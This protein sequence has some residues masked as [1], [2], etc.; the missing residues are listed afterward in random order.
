MRQP[1][2]ALAWKHTAPHHVNLCSEKNS[3]HS[4]LTDR[5]PNAVTRVLLTAAASEVWTCENL[6]RAS[7]EERGC[8]CFGCGSDRLDGVK[9]V[10]FVH[11]S[12]GASYRRRE[13]GK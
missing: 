8:N 6:K 12:G 3:K 2:L 11:L 5:I 7:E 9:R 10:F 4:Q 1:C 13:M